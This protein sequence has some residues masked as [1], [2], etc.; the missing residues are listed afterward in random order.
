MNISSALEIIRNAPPQVLQNHKHEAIE[1]FREIE[2]R[3]RELDSPE[4]DSSIRA[5]TAVANG[6]GT[7]ESLSEVASIQPP[8]SV[9]RHSVTPQART[10]SPSHT[11]NLFTALNKISSLV[12]K[13]T[14]LRPSMVLGIKR[15]RVCDRRLADVRRIDG[16][17]QAEPKYKILRVL[18]QRSLVL[19]GEKSGYL[20]VENYC[21]I[22]SSKKRGK[23][24]RGRQGNIALYIREEL[25]IGKEDKDFAI[26][27]VSAGIKQLATERLLKKRLEEAGQHGSASGISAFTALVVRPFRCLKYEEIPEFLDSLLESDSMDLSTLTDNPELEHALPVPISEVIRVTSAWFD[28]LQTYYN[29]EYDNYEVDSALICSCL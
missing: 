27:A 1:A 2:A 3:L 25:A 6:P 24:N 29:S 26:R 4:S 17:P 16:E 7:R 9:E 5:S 10:N 19:Q 14:K 18:A 21:K 22:A 28:E 13:F 8:L 12:W 23:V 20:D 11:T 15:P